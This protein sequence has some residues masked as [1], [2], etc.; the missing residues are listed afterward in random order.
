MA[1]DGM[2][3]MNMGDMA[4]GDG[5]PSLGS[6]QQNYWAVV[7]A[8]IATSALINVLSIIMYRQR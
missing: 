8:A 3:G 4:M 2:E 6:F 7:G 1:M 5:I